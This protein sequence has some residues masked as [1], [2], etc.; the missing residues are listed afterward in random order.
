[1]GIYT[2]ASKL[3]LVHFGCVSSLF[4]IRLPP[5]MLLMSILDN[6]NLHPSLQLSMPLYA[7]N[8]VTVRASYI[9]SLQCLKR[10]EKVNIFLFRLLLFFGTRIKSHQVSWNLQKFARI[11]LRKHQHQLYT[12][13]CY[14]VWFIPVLLHNISS[15]VCY[16][17]S[18]L[19]RDF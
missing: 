7:E 15:Y 3:L 19:S 8:R 17:S 10:T 4:W 6:K 1:M 9:T 18:F 11:G 5:T 14:V 13:I 12:L 2:D 16:S